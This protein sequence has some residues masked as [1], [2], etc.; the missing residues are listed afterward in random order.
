ML[1]DHPF[2]KEVAKKFMNKDLYKEVRYKDLNNQD[3]KNLIAVYLGMC[4]E[5]DHNIGR[6]LE[7]LEQ[8]NLH[9]DTLIIF[10]SD[11]GELLGENRMWGK[12]GWWDSSYRI[13]L[14]IY[15]P[16]EKNYEISD[17]TESVDLA[18]TILDWL[19]TDIPVLSLI[20]I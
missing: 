15:N 1:N 9:N 5:V 12:L 7:S 4:A 3:K 8:N 13:P 20:H 14:I 17:F 2:L 18:P 10:T 16:G 11:H 6:I 19:K